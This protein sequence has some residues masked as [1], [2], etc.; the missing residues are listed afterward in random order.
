[1]LSKEPFREV[2]GSSAACPEF[3]TELRVSCHIMVRTI[4]ASERMRAARAER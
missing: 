4:L 1:M 2:I 3:K